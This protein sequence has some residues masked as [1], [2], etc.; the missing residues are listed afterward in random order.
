M[1]AVVV[2][3]LVAVGLPGDDASAPGVTVELLPTP[4]PG[5]VA[6]P[7]V[8]PSPAAPTPPVAVSGFI[9]PIAGACLPENDYLM[10]GAPRQ[11]RQGVH[12]GVDFYDSDN[13]ALIGLGTEVLAA[14]EGTVVRADWDYRD[15][16]PGTLIELVAQVARGEGSSREVMDALRGQQVWVHHGGRVVTRYG[17]LSG[18]ADG[19]AVGARVEQGALI[20]HVGDSG[21]PESVIDPGTQVHLHFEIRVG[22]GFLG[23][24][25]ESAEVRTLYEEAFTP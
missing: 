1:G 18:I 10:P 13:C 9:Y 16:T 14:K 15:L 3:T 21:T 2:A 4:T 8:R 19:L 24:G 17:H 7:T 20:G 23:Q 12:E 11:Y 5:T 25:R 22:D 6:R